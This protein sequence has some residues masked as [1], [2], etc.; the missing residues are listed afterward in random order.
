MT[1]DGNVW[2]EDFSVRSYESDCTGRLRM[3]SLFNYFQ[4]IAGNH[5]VHLGI[6]YE[7][8]KDLGYVWVLSRARVRIRKLPA[9]GEGGVI[10][11]WHVTTEGLMYIRDFR[12]TDRDGN[13]LLDAATGWLLVDTAAFRPHTADALPIPLPSNENGRTLNE[14]LKKLVPVRDMRPAYERNVHLSDLDVNNHVNNARYLEWLFDCYDDG[15]VRSHSPG[16]LQ[17]NYVGETTLGDTVALSRG[18]DA[19]S[20]DLHYI[21]AVSRRRGSRVV[22]AVVGWETRRP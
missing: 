2:Q 14:Q 8:L 18:E 3:A 10:R 7:V 9:W 15:F 12:M 21:E 17:V 11:T 4:E 13:V 5:V 16:F 6:G 22:Q 1:A 19:S 20:P